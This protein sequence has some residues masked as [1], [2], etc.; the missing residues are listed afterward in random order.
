MKKK[1]RKIRILIIPS[2]YP[3]DGGEFFRDHAE[4]LCNEEYEVHVIVK[5]I[6][7]L[8]GNSLVNIINTYKRRTENEN[9]VL[10]QREGFIK[11]P[12]LEKMSIRLWIKS[13][14]RQIRIYFKDYGQPD[15][16]IAHSAV[17]GGAVAIR[18][19]HT[20]SIPFILYEHRSRFATADRLARGF[21]R[22]WHMCELKKIFAGAERIVVVSDSL[23]AGIEKIEPEVK[24]TISVIPDL[25][26]TDFF[27]PSEKRDTSPFIFISVALLEE[28]KGLRYLLEAFH[29]FLKR[30]QGN[31]EL[32]IAGA[33]S[34]EKN[35]KKYSVELGL[36]GKVRFPGFLTKKGVKE[37]MQQSHVFILPSIIEAFGVVLI[38]AMAVGLPVIATK[39]GGP[40]SIVNSES[41]LLVPVRDA[42]GLSEAMEKMYLNYGDYNQKK[43]RDHTMNHF[44]YKAVSS[45]WHKLIKETIYEHNRT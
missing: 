7:G 27:T 43:I 45:Q 29:E 35:L 20:F 40:Q 1:N 5:R 4:A 24:N 30:V 22:D 18:V 19:S 17:W 37:A 13:Y 41:G 10:V 8:S 21:F 23:C 11:L 34:L 33:G 25:V 38:E 39:S 31:F 26:N 42:E 15:V 9:G 12:L 14:I 32:H 3:P 44:S 2:W 16:I 6:I 36:K 28:V